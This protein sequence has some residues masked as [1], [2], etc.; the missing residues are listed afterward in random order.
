M[1]TGDMNTISTANNVT[2]LDVVETGR[3]RRFS[4]EAKR[5]IVEESYS[6]G[7]PV[8]AVARRH[9]IVPSHLFEWRRRARQGAFGAMDVKGGECAFVAAVVEPEPTKSEVNRQ[10]DTRRE[11]PSGRME[12]ALASGVRLTVGTDVDIAAL[13]RVLSVLERR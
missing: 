12:I 3:R 5:R 8:S 1:V 11:Q 7:D 9:G 6:S 4:I 2:V 10:D 13:S